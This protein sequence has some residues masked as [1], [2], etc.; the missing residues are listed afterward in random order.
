MRRNGNN[1]RKASTI[2]LYNGGT[3]TKAQYWSAIR[4]ALRSKM[5]WW[6]PANEALLASR[7]PY[8]G[9]NKLQK[10]EHLCA[11]C[12]QWHIRKNV[13]IDHIVPCGSLNGPEDL[14]PFL[15]RLTP[16]SP[17]AYQVLCKECHNVKT[18]EERRN[19]KSD[20][21]IRQ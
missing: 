17:D 13:A 10:W 1:M 6:K 5:R 14:A 20:K 16:E 3:W 4:S 21:A 15:E 18:Q 2:K 7:R 8:K 11:H 9:P 19:A 12:G